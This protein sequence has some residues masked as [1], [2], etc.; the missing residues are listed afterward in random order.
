MSQILADRMASL[1]LNSSGDGRET[2]KNSLLVP[3][4]SSLPLNSSEVGLTGVSEE[5]KDEFTCDFE[6][7]DTRIAT[8]GN[9]DSGKSTLIGVLTRGTLDDGRGSARSLVMKHKHEIEN[10]RTSAVSTEIMGFK[11]DGSQHLPT[12][13]NH[14]Q[15]WQEI[16]SHATHNVTL[17]DLVSRILDNLL[18]DNSNKRL[19][20]FLVRA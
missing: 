16:G 11:D 2:A 17:I 18:M 10:G 12:T 13:R 5:E 15:R 1:A 14:N 4:E 9:V 20:I 7:N 6:V 3:K 19:P 8:I